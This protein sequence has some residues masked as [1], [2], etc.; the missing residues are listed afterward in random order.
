[1]SSLS[2]SNIN[3]LILAGK[4]NSDP[5]SEVENK[6]FLD[7][8]GKLSISWVI[9]ALTQSKYLANEP[10]I[11]VKPTQVKLFEDKLGLSGTRYRLIE[12]NGSPIDAIIS[13]SLNLAKNSPAQKL[14]ITTADHPLL[15]P[16]MVDHFIEAA[17]TQRSELAFGVVNGKRY[18]PSL[19]KRTWH[20][21]N[22]D[23]WLSGANL[24]FF[25]VDKLTGQV[26]FATRLVEGFRKKPILMSLSLALQNLSFIFKLIRQTAQLE[27]ANEILSDASGIKVRLIELP[28]SEACIDIDKA[29]DLEMARRIMLSRSQAS[30]SNPSGSLLGI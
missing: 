16:E 28:Y 7:I 12:N 20:R 8:K 30:S 27:D 10:F 29:S 19:L 2:P 6:A 9:Q 22:P 25:E 26:I 11:S 17:I 13:C 3:A 23:C 4:R 1:M 21:L 18:P 15:T 24:F 14:L 5:F